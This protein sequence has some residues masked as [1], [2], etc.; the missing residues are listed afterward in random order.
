MKLFEIFRGI[1]TEI[2]NTSRDLRWKKL[3][4]TTEYATFSSETQ[5][6]AIYIS[7]IDLH[8]FTLPDTLE[9]YRNLKVLNIVFGVVNKD[10]QVELALTKQNKPFLPLSVVKN[11]ILHR[12]SHVKADIVVFAAKS[13]HETREDFEK[14][15]GLYSTLVSA[16]AK[17]GN[18][19]FKRYKDKSGTY[20]VL[21]K[22][23]ITQQL[24]K[25]QHRAIQSYIVDKLTVVDKLKQIVG[26]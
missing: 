8:K 9:Q 26:K 24:T 12:S 21:I 7:D 17:Q 10:G 19:S 15:S 14:R 5:T 1:L 23:E 16:Y 18:F 25:K 11:A 22:Y 3:D 6:F 2:G 4:S 20:F 13:E